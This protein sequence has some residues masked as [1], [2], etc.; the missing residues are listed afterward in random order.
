MLNKRLIKIIPDIQNE[1]KDGVEPSL[2]DLQSDTFPL[3]YL[4]LNETKHEPTS[5]FRCMPYET[6]CFFLHMVS[7]TYMPS[8]NHETQLLIAHSVVFKA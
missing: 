4:A 5:F 3:C 1:A 6:S 8:G 2:Q 7:Y